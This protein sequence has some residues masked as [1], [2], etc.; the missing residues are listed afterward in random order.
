MIDAAKIADLVI[1]TIDGSYGFEMETF[2]FLNILATHG[3]PKV[4]GVLT[5]LDGFKQASRLRRVKK[6]LKQR[7]WVELYQGA[8]LFY[9]SGLSHG[10]YP[11]S[12]IHNLAL[13]LSRVRFR[14]LVWRNTHSYVVVDRVEDVT[15]SMEINRFADVDRDMVLFG[16]VRGTHFRAGSHI[17]IPGAGEFI[18]NTVDALPDPLP[19]PERDP[20]KRSLNRSLNAKETLLYSPNSDIGSTI[21]M[22]KD[23]IY[24]NMPHIHFTKPELL[25]KGSKGSM[26]LPGDPD[27]DEEEESFDENEDDETTTK[28]HKSNVNIRTADGVSL[29]RGL[30]EVSTGMD[31]ALEDAGLRLFPAS[32]LIMGRD[33]ED[34]LGKYKRRPVG[35]SLGISGLSYDNDDNNEDDEFDD[36]GDD[37]DGEFDEDD[38]GEF[39]EDED[40]DDDDDG[41]GEFDDD[42][43]QDFEDEDEE[44]E[45]D[46]DESLQKRPLPEKRPRFSSSS[47]ATSSLSALRTGHANKMTTGDRAYLDRRQSLQNISE[48]VYGK[49]D[50]VDNNDMAVDDDEDDAA[51][52]RVK[53]TGES[54]AIGLTAKVS[55]VSWKGDVPTSQILALDAPDAPDASLAPIAPI[56]NLVETIYA[57]KKST[58]NS[59]NETSNS[60]DFWNDADLREKVLRPR[61]VTAAYAAAMAEHASKNKSTE[62]EDD[63][64]DDFDDEDDL[65]GYNDESDADGSFEDLEVAE[66]NPQSQDLSNSGSAVEIA[67]ARA[68]AAADKALHKMRLGKELEEADRELANGLNEDDEEISKKKDEDAEADEDPSNEI[69]AEL[70][71]AQARA[72]AQKK[73]NRSEWEGMDATARYNITGFPAGT[74]VRLSIRA[75]PVEF[76]RVSA[77]RPDLPIIV[78]AYPVG[79]GS[80]GLTYMRLRFKRHRW[81]TKVLKTNDPLIF[82]VGW[83]RFQS[84]P[85][86]SIQDANERFRYLK[87]TPEH[88]HCYA[89]IYGPYIPPNTGVVAFQTI[90]E[91]TA[92]FRIVGSGVVLE[93]DA[94]GENFRIMKKLKLVGYPFKIFKNTAFVRGMFNSP[95]EVAKYEGA[96]LRTVSGIRGAIKKSV[97]EGP[98]GT[99]RATFE[100]KV[101]MSDTIFC[102]AWVPVSA[103]P[104]YNPITSYLA[105]AHADSKVKKI[106]DKEEQDDDDEEEDSD[107]AGTDIPTNPLG[108]PLMR[109]HKEL[110]KING[111]SVVPQADSLYKTIERAPRRFNPLQIPSKLQSKLPFSSKPKQ[112]AAKTSSGKGY[113]ARRAVIADKKEREAYTL[114][115]QVFTL[116]NAKD[117]KEAEAAA[118]KKEKRESLLEAEAEAKRLATRAARKRSYAEMGM[119]EARAAEEGAVGI[120]L[121]VKRR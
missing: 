42:E 36:D 80:E 3:M 12:E 56:D 68:A 112:M 65:Y 46:I 71:E 72:D 73:I 118:E 33:A 44:D 20:T 48:L 50:Y 98:P 74:Y 90:A 30:Q 7:F 84:L 23:A 53:T 29:V 78:G 81:Q 18:V 21:R 89:T 77:N 8:K 11:K 82:S 1:L 17:T 93:A 2:E 115:Q 117:K 83:R 108:I 57:L 19:L 64:N 92:A 79:E 104:F 10:L 75:M 87:Y 105:L 35:A 119:R 97:R 94:A 58:L 95:L 34:A 24:I 27:N 14:P 102:R 86:Y 54:A 22:D 100:D 109:S 13:F 9:L 52:F 120:Q 25:T 99:F 43:E 107:D 28:K 76:S 45:D 101:L 110:R 5:K 4:M 88:M 38:D 59:E 16:Y 51:F 66:T 113:L 91:N 41:G 116:R 55:Q 85:L 62:N 40:D 103:T 61:F 6:D 37:D 26:N 15:P 49:V 114:L 32:N 70:A 96:K 121:G 69:T 60:L 63:E 106:K 39:D 31:E 67:A 47:E 111:I